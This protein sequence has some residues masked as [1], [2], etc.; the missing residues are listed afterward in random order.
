MLITKEITICI[1]NRNVNYYK[2][3]NYDCVAGEEITVKVCDLPN[4]S[5]VKID[6]LCDFCKKEISKKSYHG[7]LKSR[8]KLNLDCCDNG[9]CVG[10]KNNLIRRIPLNEIITYI[11]KQ[12][13]N[14]INVE[15]EYV[16][17]KSRVIL[18]CKNG[19]KMGYEISAFKK[20]RRCSI[21]KGTHQQNH[22]YDEVFDYFELQ[23]C[24][25]LDSEYKNMKSALNYIC[26]CGTKS[27]ISYYDFMKGHRC[28]NCGGNTRYKYIEV[29]NIFK[30]NDCEL[31]S[32][33]YSN[34]KELLDYICKCGNESQITLS[35]FIN[36][37]RCNTCYREN[38]KGENH[39]FWNP[40]KTLAERQDDRKYN[41]YKHWQKSVFE[42]DDYRCQACGDKRGGNLN[43]HHL[44]G[45]NWCIEKRVDIDNGITLC[46]ECHK[47]FHA[48][49]GYGDNTTEQFESFI[50]KQLV[51]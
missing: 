13:Y 12:G 1:T 33:E 47:E 32:K 10:K 40:N 7:Y 6:V 49:Y 15:G 28:R 39:P 25:L 44:D 8:E 19:H 36:G 43:A 45:Y 22:D 11:V 17:S 27:K 42:R 37:V 30:E 2:D 3:K 46:V 9:K 24:Y 48:N 21:C 29:F 20:G 5:G 26:S 4:G 23:G 14:F 18:E 16:N 41:E 51:S 35:N 34:N 50:G 38:N 31:L